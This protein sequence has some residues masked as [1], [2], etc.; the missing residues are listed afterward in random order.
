MRILII[1][2]ERRAANQLKL[3]LKASNFEYE[4][5]DTIDSV[6]EAVLW[7]QHN[8]MPDLVFMDIQLADGLSFEI[9]QK[10]EVEGPIIFTTAFDHAERVGYLFHIR[11]I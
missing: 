10:T 3:M 7:F 6:E 11:G 1:E 2:D 4:L 5:L 9:F 8:N